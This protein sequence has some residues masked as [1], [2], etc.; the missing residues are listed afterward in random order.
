MRHHADGSRASNGETAP[1]DTGQERATRVRW[2]VFA[3]ACGAS[4]FLYLH[5]Y[6]WNFIRPE[7]EKEFGLNNT[8]LEALFSAF[9]ASYAVGQIPSGVICD[10]FGA[11]TFLAVTMALWSLILPFFGMSSTVYQLGGLRFAFGLAQAGCYPALSHVTRTWFPRSSRTIMQGIIVSFF[12]RSG[13]AMASIVMGTVLVG[14]LGFSWRSSLTIMAAAGLAF[15]VVFWLLYR[16]RPELDPRVNRAE[17]ELIRE[18]EVDA[19]GPPVLPPGRVLR[20]RSML[21]FI[22]HQFMNAGADFIYVSLMGS[23]FIK[24]HGMDVASAGLLV[25]LPLWGGALGGV[26]GGFVNDGL[27]YATSSRRWSRRLAGFSG[28]F[29]ACLSMLVAMQPMS[30]IAVACCLFVVKF[31]TDSTQPT[32]WGTCTDLGGRY[33]ATTFSVINTAGNVGQLVTPLLAGG[34]LDFY[35]AHVIV[36]GVEQTIT[37]YTPML[38][39]SPVCT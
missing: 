30:G 15:A 12:G 22:L 3:L 9:S 37:D 21:V 39:W 4:W 27:I 26:A 24:A 10:L 35:S 28:H 17:C 31:C 29:L 5:R 20:N 38:R 25:S 19:P 33:S 16:N 36:N 1:V 32:V 11:H 13:G 14:L 2:L 34:L 23:Y 6:T 8:Q 7:L 18:G